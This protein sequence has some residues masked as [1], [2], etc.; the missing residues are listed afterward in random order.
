MGKLNPME[1]QLNKDESKIEEKLYKA[2]GGR[3]ASPSGQRAR[4]SSWISR[5]KKSSNHAVRR[6]AFLSMW[7]SKCIFHFEL[8]LF[9][10]PFTFG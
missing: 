7:M 1:L 10:K 9:I 8:V 6:A 2:F 5:F 4:F 3:T